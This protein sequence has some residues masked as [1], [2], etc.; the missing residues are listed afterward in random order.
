L[1]SRQIKASNPA[2]VPLK[3]RIYSFLLDCCLTLIGASCRVE[4]FEN[5][6]RFEQLLRCGS[7]SILAAWHN[8]VFFISY[9]LKTKFIRKGGKIAMLSSLSND[10]EIGAHLGE[11]SGAR[12]V[13]GS[14]SKGGTEGFRRF[15]RLMKKEG[16]STIILPDG[17][18][19]PKYQAKMGV[20]MLAKMTGAAVIPIS[21]AADRFWRIPSW[22]RMIIP[23]PFARICVVVG[24]DILVDRSLEDDELELARQK[25]ESELNTLGERAGRIFKSV[26]SDEI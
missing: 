8:R 6:K 10:G 12:A 3:I 18:K 2:G 20:A 15:Y 26:D 13:R 5:G 9:F 14:A 25:I 23:K 19:G 22:D 16:Y 11:K 17:S 4:R 24:K 21:Y 1:N 7:P